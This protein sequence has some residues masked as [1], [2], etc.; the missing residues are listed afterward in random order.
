MTGFAALAAAPV[1][2]KAPGLLRNAGDIRRIR[3]VGQRTGETIDTVYWVEGEYIP[4]AMSEISFFM[5][6]W[7]EN[8]LKAFDPRTVDLMAA[9]HNKLGC[10]EPWLVISGYRSKA[11]NDLLRRT[12]R[13]V[14]SNSY[15]I[16]A[17]ACDMRLRSRTVGQV[18]AAAK[19]CDTGG[20]GRYTRANFVHMDCG[21]NRTWGR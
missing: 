21:P 16:Q 11:T 15:H 14:A 17:M 13:G 10:E 19:S 3:L 20:V 1:Y 7:R 2:A 4:E 5:R 18:T 8:Q 6:D 12:K 9:T